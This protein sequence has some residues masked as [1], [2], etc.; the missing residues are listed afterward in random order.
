MSEREETHGA[1]TG[2]QPLLR[3]FAR[4]RDGYAI[5]LT[6]VALPL[7]VG[8]AAWVIDASRVTN[9]HTDLQN[10]TDAM[11]LAGARELDGRNDAITRAEAAIAAM[12]ENQ[13]W[14]GDGGDNGSM[15]TKID[16]SYAPGGADN[17]VDVIFLG[18][19]PD[20]DNTP[21]GTGACDSS[22][23]TNTDCTVKGGT[24]AERSNNAKYVL[25]RSNVENVRTIFPLPLLGRDDIGVRAEAVATY[26]AAACDVTPIFICNPYEGTANPDFN[27]RFENGEM[28]GRQFSMTLNGGTT[29]EP[30]NFGYLAVNGSGAS[31]LRDA[32]ATNSPGVCY[33]HDDTETEPGGNI[34]PAEQAIATRFGIY[35]GP[36]GGMSN[37]YDYRPARNVRMGQDY[38]ASKRNP[39]CSKYEAEANPMDA[40]PFPPGAP[41]IPIGGATMS[42]TATWDL[43]RYWQVSHGGL[44]S[45]PNPAVAPPAAPSGIRG[46]RA[47]MPPTSTTTVDTPSRYD[48]YKYEM[49]NNLTGNVAPG[50]EKGT[51]Q[52][53]GGTADT[54]D[55]NDPL[56]D[57]RTIFAAVLNCTEQFSGSGGGRQ[58]VE[59]AAYARMFLTKPMVTIGSNKYI[60]LEV[61]DVT[62]QGGMGTVEPFLREE[63]EL[64]R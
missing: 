12:T 52:C 3:R 45:A 46:Y 63:A 5:T 15:G 50:G 47:S 59:A 33:T 38:G 10:A 29:V 24:L 19:I 27:A 30:G 17:D 6:L 54:S 55:I 4:E 61:V 56:N 8:V 60:S 1:V 2:R 51:T 20:S 25:V 64:V 18:A 62:G 37:D 32:L 26:T 16:V 9:L 41:T 48:V 40:M 49:Q 7:I 13:A 23:T 22:A 53:Y 31:V 57:R 14:F 36:L 44:T 35:M 58:S 42:A 34:G 39:S 28:Y 43:D 21:I 11:A